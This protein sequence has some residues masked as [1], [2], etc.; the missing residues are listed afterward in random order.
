MD[1]H[2]IGKKTPWAINTQL[3]PLF[4]PLNNYLSMTCTF[5][6]LAFDGHERFVPDKPSLGVPCHQGAYLAQKAFSVVQK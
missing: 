2:K 6:N 1:H 4:Q 3:P 5:I